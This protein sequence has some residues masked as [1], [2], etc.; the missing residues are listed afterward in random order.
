MKNGFGIFEIYQP[1]RGPQPNRF[2]ATGYVTDDF[3]GY[4][5][6]GL[7][8]EHARN[9][10]DRGFETEILQTIRMMPKY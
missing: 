7:A 10:I 9:L 3:T 4:P 1:N 2:E 5:L 6:D 8:E